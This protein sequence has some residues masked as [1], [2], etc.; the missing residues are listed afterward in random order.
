MK[1][2]AIITFLF[3]LYV[4]CQTREKTLTVGFF[5]HT[6][7]I[8]PIYYDENTTDEQIITKYK[9]AKPKPYCGYVLY[10]NDSLHYAAVVF[11]KYFSLKKHYVFYYFPDGDMKQ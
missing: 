11:H 6:I 2:I 8:L 1:K 5:S 7:K 4:C 9:N 3:P 10:K